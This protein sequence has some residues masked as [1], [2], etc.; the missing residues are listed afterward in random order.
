[1][2]FDSVMLARIAAD[3]QRTV[4]GARVQRVFMSGLD[5]IVLDLRRKLPRP[6]LMLS[7]SAEFGRAH[8]CADAVPGPVTN[9]PIGDILRKHLR[10]ATLVG[11]RQVSFDRILH[12]DF[13]NCVGLGPASKASLVAEI[14]GRHAN[15]ALLDEDE[16]IIACAKHVPARVNRYRETLPNLQ[17]TPPPGFGRLDPHYVTPQALA[18][19]AGGRD[20]VALRKFIRGTINGASDLL[21][22]ELAVRSGVPDD[23]AVDRLPAGW[24]DAICAALVDIIAETEAEGPAFL[25]AHETGPAS[26]EFAYP[27]VLQ[28]SLDLTSARTEDLS[29]GLEE[30]V[31][32]KQVGRRIRE[33]SDRLRGFAQRA[34]KKAIAREKERR[35]ALNQADDAEN[36]R[37]RGEL[38]LAN[39]HAIPSGTE[40]V[41]VTDYY[42]PEQGQITIQLDPNYS[43]KENAQAI[44]ARYK[45]A[46]RIRDRVPELLRRAVVEREYV[47]GLIDQI[48][49]ADSL[50][51]LG[52]IEHEM[53]KGGYIGEQAQRKHKPP[54]MG[55]IEPSRSASSDGYAILYGKTGAQNDAVIRAANP[56]DL[57]F[58][59]K[60]GPGGHVVV[61]TDGRPDQV[62]ETT[63][64]QAAGMA[65]ALSR[66]RTD[67]R[68]DVNYTEAKHLR[69]PRGAPPG[70]VTYKDFKTVT[71]APVRLPDARGPDNDG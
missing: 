25:Y 37:R 26:P 19:A 12:L 34:L 33:R 21:L 29:E 45:R 44:F 22:D 52:E 3:L 54:T 62:P 42:D 53:L 8:L 49:T 51:Q 57:W 36:L 61:R 18:H 48:N 38:I 7:W 31:H 17:Y 41:S 55:A 23:S 68:A 27:L 28:S 6:Q 20:D 4:I 70:F 43:A 47:E 24:E 13:A 50:S 69:K 9:L 65:A 2:L 40:E 66:W 30:L 1:M 39:L 15:L 5:E 71:V 10:G 35:K 56:D 60:E 11:A 14:M 16:T 59:V 67:R 32:F 46:Q 58:H 63:I 64:E